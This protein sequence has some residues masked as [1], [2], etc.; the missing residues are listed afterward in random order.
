[1][2]VTIQE[3]EAAINFWRQRTPPVGDE[4][5]LSTE[6]SALAKPYAI[7]IMQGAQRMPLDLMGASAQLAIKQYQTEIS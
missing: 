2:F 6:V 4:Q 3:L 5:A 7:L 1:M